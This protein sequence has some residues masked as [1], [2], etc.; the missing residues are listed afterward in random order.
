[1]KNYFISF[2]IFII[3]FLCSFEKVY[4]E[5]Q[6]NYSMTIDNFEENDNEYILST[7]TSIDK[8]QQGNYYIADLANNRILKLDC[9]M[10]KIGEIQN[11]DMPI[12]VFIDA[13]QNILIY[14]YLIHKSK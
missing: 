14:E 7:P 4:A 1:M 8:D 2:I 6:I 12:T 9:Y 3:V 5:Y 11:L 13:Q 10:N